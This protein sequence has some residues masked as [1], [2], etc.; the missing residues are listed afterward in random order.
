M[1]EDSKLPEITPTTDPAV[2]SAWL[3]RAWASVV[4]F[5]FPTLCPYC[6]QHEAG[7][8]AGSLFCQQCETN[9]VE[10]SGRQCLRCSASV[11]PYV[12]VSQGCVHCSQER[13]AFEAVCSL[14]PYREG[15]KSACLRAKMRS[16]HSLTVGLAQQIWRWRQT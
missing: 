11:G 10:F 1:R 2:S 7:S 12:D 15:L 5:C 8:E 3:R 13:F 9:C 16:G 6:E 14:G 4:D